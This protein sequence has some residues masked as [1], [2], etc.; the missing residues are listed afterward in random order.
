MTFPLI[1]GKDCNV[2][3]HNESKETPPLGRATERS[4]EIPI[5]DLGVFNSL[6]L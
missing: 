1:Q 5:L 3:A 2:H 6:K 4:S